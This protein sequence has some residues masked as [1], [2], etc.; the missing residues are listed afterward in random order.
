MLWMT[1]GGLVL[2]L[3]GLLVVMKTKATLV[4]AIIALVGAALAVTMFI[5]VQ[6]EDAKNAAKCESVS[7]SYGGDVCYISGVEKDLKEIGL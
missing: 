7:G 6:K 1:V 2:L 5:T 4:G 3:A